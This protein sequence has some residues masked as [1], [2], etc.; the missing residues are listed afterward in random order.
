MASVY[1]IQKSSVS[2]SNL[3]R[4]RVRDLSVTSRLW[5]RGVRSRG[6]TSICCR[7]R[8]RSRWLLFHRISGLLIACRG[9]SNIRCCRLRLSNDLGLWGVAVTT[10]SSRTS[11]AST[12]AHTD[13]Y[14]DANDYWYDDK[15]N[16]PSNGTSNYDVD[17]ELGQSWKNC[18]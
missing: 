9:C 5:L 6:I 7:I 4:G 8:R 14:H 1:K 13:T 2:I 18:M 16:K 17:V 10:A 3:S 11:S 12:S 15:E